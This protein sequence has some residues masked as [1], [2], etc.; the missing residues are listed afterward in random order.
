M[1][2]FTK[3]GGFM[4]KIF[5]A[6]LAA[7]MCV[8]LSV[9]VLADFQGETT[10]NLLSEFKEIAQESDYSDETLIPYIGE[11]VN[12][13]SEFSDD[14]LISI[15]SNNTET[16][17]YRRGILETYLSKYDFSIKDK[18]F[19]TLL[20]DSWFDNNMKPL[21]ITCLSDEL[22]S[23]PET[24]D[25]L[26]A[27]ANSE[28]ETLVYHAIKSLA[29]I[30]NQVAIQIAENILSNVKFEP[31][32]KVNIALDILA[33]YYADMDYEE[34]NT[35]EISNFIEKLSSLY[36]GTTSEEIRWAVENALEYLD[37]PEAQQAAEYLKSITP[38]PYAN[39]AG[40]YAV[41]R[42]G[43]EIIGSVV[44]NWHTA[45]VTAGI[46]ASGTYA[47]ASGT[48]LTT[49]LVSYSSFLNGNTFKG[50]YKPSSVS[51]YS[52]KWDAV[53]STAK[54]LANLHIP[55]VAVECITY[56]TIPAGQ[57]HYKPADIKAIRCDGFVEYCFEYNGIRV[58]GPISGDAWDIS[59]ND[60]YAQ[61][62]HNGVAAITPKSQ[63]ENYMDQV[64]LS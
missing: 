60:A 53:V 44:T 5:G 35:L 2:I 61:D 33:H 47:E 19:L 4:K 36:M 50:Y 11:L 38:D 6:F 58:Y 20:Q 27:L 13:S 12:R 17:N 1:V 3:G 10:P 22:L 42:D 30:D 51:N 28:S 7:I 14:E 41:Y 48:G 64:D 15:I 46:G 39:G 8:S 26:T 52:G 31:D 34:T 54:T 9:P 23:N 24:K 57:T 45:I 43:V 40:G 63:A 62:V 16:P 55:Y 21:I 18:R 56:D 49:G 32:A 29:V 59:L 25:V 37:T